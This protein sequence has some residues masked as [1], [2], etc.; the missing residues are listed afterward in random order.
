MTMK[1]VYL[2]L[3][4]EHNFAPNWGEQYQDWWT[5]SICWM[6]RL[7]DV[8]QR[9]FE[10]RTI[11]ICNSDKHSSQ[12]G[13]RHFKFRQFQFVIETDTFW[14]TSWLMDLLYFWD[15]RQSDV[16]F[17]LKNPHK[18]KSWNNQEKI[19]YVFKSQINLEKIRTNSN[20]D[21]IIL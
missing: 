15:G 10:I 1:M 8:R 16:R 9:H 7:S 2:R 5:A 11:T 6:P 4:D 12:F 3:R 13:Q 14:T 20:Y 17:L 18:F 19:L 21:G